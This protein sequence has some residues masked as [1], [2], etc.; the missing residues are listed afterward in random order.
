MKRSAL[1]HAPLQIKT[2][3]SLSRARRATADARRGMKEGGATTSRRQQP[4]ATRAATAPPAS[5]RRP[6]RLDLLEF[7][8]HKSARA[9]RSHAVDSEK[10]FLRPRR[11]RLEPVRDGGVAYGPK[12]PLHPCIPAHLISFCFWCPTA[13][14]FQ[15]LLFCLVCMHLLKQNWRVTVRCAGIDPFSGSQAQSHTAAVTLFDSCDCD[16]RCS[17]CMRTLSSC[18]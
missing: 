13:P 7:L 14:A 6:A 17:A 3:G 11:R 4:V 12:L 10:H 5:N 16:G 18:H 15:F 9:R 2:S 8:T 1:A